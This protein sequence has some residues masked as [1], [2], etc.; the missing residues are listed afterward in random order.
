MSNLLK[1]LSF[2]HSLGKSVSSPKILRNI[3]FVNITQINVEEKAKIRI[4]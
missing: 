3:K 4:L 2:L 1:C